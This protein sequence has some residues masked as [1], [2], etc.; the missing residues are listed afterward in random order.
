MAT[1]ISVKSMDHVVLTV[2]SVDATVK[3][4]TEILGMKHESFCSPRNPE[5]TRHALIFGNQKINLHSAASPWEPHAQTPLSGSADLCFL[6]DMPVEQVHT[7]LN[8]AGVTVLE[9][10]KVVSRVGAVGKL[11]SVYV[12]DPDGNLIEISNYE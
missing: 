9:D 11:R 1:S 6:T 4:Y 3:F 7:Q 2:K 10:N 12:R 5:V 8:E